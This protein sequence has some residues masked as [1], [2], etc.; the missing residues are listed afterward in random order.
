MR[1]L[2]SEMPP[3]NE[4]CIFVRLKQIIQVN[5]MDIKGY[6][7]LIPV[8]TTNRQ[9]Y[10]MF[11]LKTTSATLCSMGSV[12]KAF[13]TDGWISLQKGLYREKFLLLL[14]KQVDANLLLGRLKGILFG[15]FSGLQKNTFA[16]PWRL[17][18]QREGKLRVFR[19]LNLKFS[20]ASKEM[21]Q[22]SNSW[23][24]SKFLNN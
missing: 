5:C 21:H 15:F 16:H 4:V 20:S 8:L 9:L 7:D 18:E 10:L 2:P 1:A 24:S 23:G 22:L 14:L 17:L 11:L 19:K 6:D 13:Y 3:M 12:A